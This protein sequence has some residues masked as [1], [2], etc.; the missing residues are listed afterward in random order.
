MVPP[1]GAVTSDMVSDLYEVP[2]KPRKYY[3]RGTRTDEHLPCDGDSRRS[4]T[5]DLRP[6][7]SWLTSELEPDTDPKPH[8][9]HQRFFYLTS[10]VGRL[11]RQLGD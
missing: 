6:Q 5:C 8:T 7:A 1:P 2:V 3:Q 10:A 11:R 4:Q 9:I